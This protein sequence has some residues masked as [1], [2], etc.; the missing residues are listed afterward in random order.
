[1]IGGPHPGI[2][3]AH[4]YDRMNEPALPGTRLPYDPPLV[5]GVLERRYKRFLADVTLPNEGTVVAWCMNT[6]AMTRCA[7][8]GSRAWLSK[9][10]NP[11]RKLKWTWEIA[12]DGDQLIGVNTQLPNA[13]VERGVHAGALPGL[14]DY[15]SV[16][17]EVKYG[18]GSRVD[19]LL[20]GHP[21]DGRPCYLEVK[22]VTLPGPG[23]TA[24]FPDAVTA[25]G[26]KHLRELA[27]VAG[28]GAR[29]VIFFL[30]QRTGSTAFAP[31]AG[32]DPAYAATLA[33]VVEAGVE[34]MAWQAAVSPEGVGLARPLEI[35][36]GGR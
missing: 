29:A 21:S 24:L 16:R 32:I 8:P 34:V 9:S 19:L 1:M 10:D 13:V 11:K 25:R 23:G 3:R 35:L 36:L 7:E 18:E 17:R 4:R 20:E 26:L 31:A 2:Q 5:E 28:A 15:A 33:E 14:A 22:S 6:G 27:Q 12:S 30:V